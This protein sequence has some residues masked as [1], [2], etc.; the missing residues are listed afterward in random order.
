VT[1]GLYAAA[2]TVATPL[3]SALLVW[4]RRRGKEHPTR[5]RERFGHAGAARPEGE[6]IWIHAAS[7]GESVS[8]LPLLDRLRADRPNTSILVTSGTVT[9]AEILAQR[10]PSGVIH[11][12][13]PVDLPA[14]VTR[15]L[16]HWRPD[17]AVWVESELWPNMIR[18]TAQ[19]GVP[20]ALINGRLSQRAA[21]RWGRCPGFARTLGGAFQV[22]LAQ[23][24]DDACRFRSIGFPMAETVGNLKLC[25][26]PPPVD[27]EA[28]SRLRAAIQGRPVWIALSIHPG[29]D[30]AV[31]TAH[32]IVRETHPKALCIAVPRH[33]NRAAAMRGVIE[34]RGLT[35]AQRSCG[36]DPD[37][38]VDVLLADTMGEIGTLLSVGAVAFVGKSLIVHGGQ[39]PIEPAKAGLAVLFGP[40]ME[41]FAAV[42]E[43]MCAA[44]AARRVASPEELGHALASALSDPLAA[45]RKS[46][47][48]ADRGR[49]VLERTVD[50]LTH[51]LETSGARA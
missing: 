7:V 45:A 10:C 34:S 17:L 39:N 6:L 40:N 26:P 49:D 20:M 3:I 33:P 28:A 48:F 37:A 35:V 21:R 31:A 43:E 13:A 25:A 15:F 5:Y 2:T 42:A 38:A 18:E 23:S 12:F 19:H 47:A 29:E 22:C 51:V 41:N 9:S 24:D 11:Q 50:A 32:R 4:R 44:G 36:E 14:A 30:V 1:P 16:D 27:A 8:V 46:L